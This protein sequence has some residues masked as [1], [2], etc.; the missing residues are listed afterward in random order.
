[1]GILDTG[2]SIDLTG[3]MALMVR[4]A[5]DVWGQE[6][7]ALLG[8]ALGRLDGSNLELIG[9]L[10]LAYAEGDSSAF[11]RWLEAHP[12]GAGHG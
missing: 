10:F 3:S 9:S 8:E 6:G 2:P 11:D 1:M 4:I 5:L 7:R 12:L